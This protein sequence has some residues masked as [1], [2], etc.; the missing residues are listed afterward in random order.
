MHVREMRNSRRR[1]ATVVE[2]ALVFLMLM[3]VVLGC[4]DFGFV[5][6]QYQ[7]LVHRSSSAARYAAINPTDLTGAQNIVLY[8]QTTIPTGK[9]SGAAG[10]F[11]LVPSMVAISRAN[12]GQPE[13]RITVTLSGYRFIFVAPFIAG[14]FVANPINVSIPVE[15]S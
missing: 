3:M 12:T 15:G 4:F 13:D 2:A 14:S 8:G 5:L 10:I 1:G 6:F 11:G 9:S 7:T